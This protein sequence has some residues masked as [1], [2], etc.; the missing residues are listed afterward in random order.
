MSWTDLNSIRAIKH[1]RDKYKIKIFVETGTFKGINAELHS[2]NFENVF[3]C[4]INQDYVNASQKRCAHLRN[5][6]ILNRNSPHFLRTLNP[7]ERHLVYLDAHFY[8]T[9]LPQN[10]RF[11]VLDE[12]K[13][14]KGK[15]C[16]VV[17]HDFDN[18]LGH[19]TYDNIPL[20]LRLIEDNLFDVNPHFNLYTN[21]LSSCNILRL[22]EKNIKELK[23]TLDRDL[24]DNLLYAW[25]EPRLT[26]RGILYALPSHLSKEE[27]RKL[28]LKEI[29][30]TR[31]HLSQEDL[32]ELDLQ[33]LRS[34]QKMAQKLL[35]VP[36][37]K[38]N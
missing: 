35:S 12:L 28:G 7:L 30:P 36:V 13:A 15:D 26:Y 27:Q 1:I 10:Q 38:I 37:I 18:G 3:S 21:E 8:D 16:A 11:V 29:Y 5:V 33:L 24:V 23:L 22:I 9:S 19:I 32:G 2:Q 4:D 14:L 25:S 17:I 34:L 31:K 20:D 6:L